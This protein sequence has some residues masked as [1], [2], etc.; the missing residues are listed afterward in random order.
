MKIKIIT[1]KN[2]EIQFKSN[3]IDREIKS[4]NHN[5]YFNYKYYILLS[6]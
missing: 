5:K 3:Y 1:R 2:E 6:F 4:L